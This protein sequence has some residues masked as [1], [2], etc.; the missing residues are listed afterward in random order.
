MR[1]VDYGVLS[2]DDG[3][4]DMAAASPESIPSAWDFSTSELSLST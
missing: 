2:Q 3:E 1:L 4:D